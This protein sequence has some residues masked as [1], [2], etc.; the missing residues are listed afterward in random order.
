MRA[1]ACAPVPGRSRQAASGPLHALTRR[2][3]HRGGR[4]VLL[5][6]GMF[7]AQAGAPA[8]TA[9]HFRPGAGPG[10][11]DSAPLEGAGRTLCLLATP[12]G[13]VFAGGAPGRRPWSL[14][15]GGALCLARLGAR[16]RA[17]RPCMMRAC[18][19]AASCWRPTRRWRP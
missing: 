13:R 9:L 5:L 8:G 11:A 19:P 3:W 4:A 16:W 15:Q 12:D 14:R 17:R 2:V 7:E 18:I 1:S 10:P 6:S